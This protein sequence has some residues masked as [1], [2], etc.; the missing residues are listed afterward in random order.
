MSIRRR[1]RQTLEG[2]RTFAA[3]VICLGLLSVVI[4]VAALFVK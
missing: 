4:V 2:E 1:L 3:G